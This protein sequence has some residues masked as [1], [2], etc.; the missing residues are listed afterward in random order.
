MKALNLGRELRRRN[1]VVPS[2]V[3]IDKQRLAPSPC[4]HHLLQ[5]QVGGLL[6]VAMCPMERQLTVAQQSGSAKVPLFM[7]ASAAEPSTKR[8]GKQP[9]A[10]PPSA[11]SPPPLPPT[12]RIFAGN[13]AAGA[14]SGCAVEAALYPIDTIKTRMQA[15]IGGGGLKALLDSGGGKGLYAGIWGNLAGTAPSSAIFISVYEPVKKWAQA[16]LPEEKQFLGPILAG[17]TAGLSS[18][19]V[20]WAARNCASNRREPKGVTAKPHHPAD[21]VWCSDC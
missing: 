19:L 21:T 9:S 5:S 7:I 8:G 2:S 1:K 10:G 16:Q 14:V 18:S 13:L 17:A 4:P 15:M 11:T 3:A 12:W 20:R 6:A